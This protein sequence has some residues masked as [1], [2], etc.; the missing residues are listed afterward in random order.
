[1]AAKKKEVDESGMDQIEAL[2][3]SKEFKDH[4]YG[5]RSGTEITIPDVIP[6]GSLMFDEFLDGGF[7]S[8]LWIRFFS[9][10]ECG[11]SSIGLAFAKA[12]QDKYGKDAFVVIFNAEGRISY[13]LVSR[14]GVNTDKSVFRIIDSNVSDMIWSFMDK[15]I[16]NNPDGKKYFFLVDSTDACNRIQ[17]EEKEVGDAEKIGGSATIIS[18]A[19]K[20]LSLPFSRSG[21]VLFMT[22]QVRDKMNTRSP[23]MAGKDASGGNAPKFY[24]SLTG[25]IK[26]P[27][28]DTYIFENPSDTKSKIIGRMVEI[29][30]IKTFNEKTGMIL[31]YPVK[32][33][34]GFWPEYEAMLYAQ[35]Y[36]L[37]TKSGA[38]FS[39]SENFISEL[40]SAGIE[41]PHKYHGEKALR[42]EFD[43]NALLCQLVLNKV[44]RALFGESKQIQE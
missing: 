21:H 4:H 31:S 8:G 25:E 42:E 24:S 11:K 44:R 13:D 5:S 10:P 35:S 17:D 2:L 15:L 14:S 36:G 39:F 23:A 27:W 41:C 6:T 19:G 1:M 7:R 33:G 20:R 3:A 28:T 32:V 12:W 43:S 26:K 38:H 37:I 34:R 30:F 40:E 22:S 29:K 9:E 16:K 18:A